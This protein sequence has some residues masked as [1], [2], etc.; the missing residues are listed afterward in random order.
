MPDR[1]VEGGR[2]VS[3]CSGFR[4]QD[5][6]SEGYSDFDGDYPPKS[7]QLIRESRERHY[8]EESSAHQCQVRE[9]HTPFGTAWRRFFK[10][11]GWRFVQ[12]KGRE[13]FNPPREVV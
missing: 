12:K 11:R 8:S 13:C 10:G 6:F 3:G 4:V 7:C 5:G 1:V 9:V 2:D